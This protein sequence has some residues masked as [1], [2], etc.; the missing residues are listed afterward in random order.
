MLKEALADVEGLEA[1]S[2]ELDTEGISYTYL[3][4][5]AMSRRSTAANAHI[6]FIMGTDTFLKIE[7]WKNAQRAPEK[8]FLPG[9]Q[10]TWIQAGRTAALHRKDTPGIRH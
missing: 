9:R 3:T 5:R 2:Y 1:S 6:Y 8:L 7:T 4:I 10:Q